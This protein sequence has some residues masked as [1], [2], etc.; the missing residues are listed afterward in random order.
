MR[1]V[2]CHRSRRRRHTTVCVERQFAEIPE[3]RGN[4]VRA[5][6][7]R[8][9]A[10]EQA[11]ARQ[12]REIRADPRTERQLQHEQAQRHARQASQPNAGYDPR[13]APQPQQQAP[14][15][16]RERHAAEQVAGGDR[17]AR[18]QVAR[19]PDDGQ[20]QQQRRH[21]QRDLGLEARERAALAAA[22]QQQQHHDDQSRGEQAV[23]ALGERVGRE[24]VAGDAGLL[25]AGDGLADL[26]VAG[27]PVTAAEPGFGMADVGAQEI[28]RQ[29][30]N[31]DQ[32]HERRE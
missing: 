6:V 30:R 2:D 8:R 11:A 24:C 23:G 12:A 4:R 25:D 20:Q 27:R 18:L 14:A 22:M 31:E 10:V 29:R 26:P 9:R 32:R 1:H 17:R 21:Q 13:A 28:N 5:G 19:R 16:R 7:R 15:Q 3:G